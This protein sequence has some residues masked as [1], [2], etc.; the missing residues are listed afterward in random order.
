MTHYFLDFTIL[1]L[2]IFCRNIDDNKDMF[3]S[4]QG[5]QTVKLRVPFQSEEIIGSGR[6]RSSAKLAASKYALKK[7]KSLEK[8]LKCATPSGIMNVRSV[9]IV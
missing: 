7:Y 3:G 2:G 5:M 4:L 9:P 8:K 1:F 6:N